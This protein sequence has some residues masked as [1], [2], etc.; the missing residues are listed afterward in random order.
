MKHLIHEQIAAIAALLNAR[1]QELEAEER[2]EMDNAAAQHHAQLDEGNL[3]CVAPAQA[4]TNTERKAGM[5]GHYF[6]ELADVSAALARIQVGVYG[7]CIECGEAIP[8][9]RLKAFP[10]AKHCLGCR[11]LHALRV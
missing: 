2:D 5:A 7:V 9:S 8:Y 4:D 10:T 11:H 1:K 3:N 6:E